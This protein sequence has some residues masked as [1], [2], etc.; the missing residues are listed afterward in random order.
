MIL[1]ETDKYLGM[2]E[3]DTIKLVET[4]EKNWNNASE[5]RE[6]YLKLNYKAEILSMG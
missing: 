6:N 2:L 5:K 3:A 4:K 1:K